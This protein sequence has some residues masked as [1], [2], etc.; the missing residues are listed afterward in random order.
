MAATFEATEKIQFEYIEGPWPGIERLACTWRLIDLPN[1]RC[2]VRVEVRYEL[3]SIL[4]STLS[5]LLFAYV[6]RSVVEAFRD[7]AQVLYGSGAKMN[8]KKFPR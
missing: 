7:R 1:S 8:Q 5:T 3:S 4:L 6:A 2:D